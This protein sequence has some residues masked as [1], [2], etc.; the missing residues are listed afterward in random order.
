MSTTGVA[1]LD[2]AAAEIDHLAGFDSDVAAAGPKAHRIPA[3]VNDGAAD[4]ADIPR[5]DGGDGLARID[6]RLREALTVGFTGPVGMRQCKALEADMLDPA[7]LLHIAGHD[8][9]L[10]DARC[11]HLGCVRGF[12]GPGDVGQHAGG[13][14]E[15]PLA[16][17]TE[18]FFDVDDEVAVV[19]CKVRPP[20]QAGRGA[21]EVD[22]FLIGVDRGD[23]HARGGPLVKRDQLDI[24]EVRPVGLEVGFFESETV[25][26]AFGVGF[27]GGHIRGDVEVTGSGQRGRGRR[28]SPTNSCPKFH[29][30]LFTA[31]RVIRQ[32]PS[33]PTCQPVSL[34]PALRIGRSS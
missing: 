8:D 27:G 21:G 13:T 28:W 22:D 9:D 25:K 20:G 26:A 32:R 11:E 24:G 15:V 23:T 31:S 18:S 16:S 1:D 14:V 12:A 29:W 4:E 30:P 17:L 33:S 10:I 7:M 34:T 19:G 2:A 6:R 3:G 5:A